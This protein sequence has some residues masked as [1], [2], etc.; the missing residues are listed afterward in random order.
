LW[1]WIFMPR[2]AR[3][4]A[5]GALHHVIFRGIER[6]KIFRD[7]KDRD[8][9]LERLGTVLSGTE[10]PC[11]AWSLMPNHVHLLL[12]TGYAP[13]AT[14]MRRLLTGH[15]AYFNRRHRRHGKLFQNRYKSILC[16]EDA[17][18][19]ELV[20]YIHLNPVRAK[21]VLDLNSLEKW[22]YSGHST[23][24]GKR[25][26][27]WQDSEYVLRLFGESLSAARKKYREYVEKGVD[28]G[29][30]PELTGG[31]LI[32]SMGG[33]AA[34]KMLRNTTRMKSDERILGDGD[35]VE[36]VLKAAEEQLES[37]YTLK[38]KG[39]DL[40]KIAQ[41]VAELS[42]IEPD[43]IWSKGKHPETVQARSVLCFWACSELGMKTT[44]LAET[45]KMAQPSVSQSVRRGEMLCKNR[46]W[47]LVE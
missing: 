32:R 22:A 18:L 30:K 31:G 44:E 27:P 11:F 23:L 40:V 8:N 47:K 12:K 37:R 13:I 43:R 5:P 46:G 33:W 35:F 6:R 16:Q 26:N 45:L 36:G 10:T 25:E 4:D 21:L 3:I 24:V 9:F 34:A 42:G 41:R 1:Y 15:A 17:Y 2:K 28:Q 20:R 38:A 29:K 39:Y 19:L 14:V 7:N